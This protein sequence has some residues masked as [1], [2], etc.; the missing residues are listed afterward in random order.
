MIKGVNMFGLTEEAMK[1]MLMKGIPDHKNAELYM[2]HITKY[3]IPNIIE[4]I[5]ANNEVILSHL[6]SD[7]TNENTGK[8]Y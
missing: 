1:K 6:E 7:R 4:V 3:L 8:S 2:D 5:A